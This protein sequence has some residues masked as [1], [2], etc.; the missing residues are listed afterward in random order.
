[1][2]HILAEELGQNKQWQARTVEDFA[3]VAARYR[4]NE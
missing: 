4:L 2:A 3:K 1:V